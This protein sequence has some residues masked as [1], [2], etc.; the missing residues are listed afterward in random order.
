VAHRS[1]DLSELLDGVLDL[2]IEDAPVGDHNDRIEK[3]GFVLLKP[4][5]LMS[6]PSNGVGLAAAGRMLDQIALA[7]AVLADRSEQ[8][9]DHVELVI[10]GENLITFLLAGFLVFVFHHLGVVF[11]DVG[12]PLAG[13]DA[14]PEVTS[15]EPLRIGRIASTIVPALVEREKPGGFALE[16]GAEEDLL[17]IHREVHQTAPELEQ[18]LPRIAVASVLL[19]GVVDRLLGEAVLEPRRWQPAAR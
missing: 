7:H 12:Q 4:D 1:R 10:P 6:Q 3:V 8:L 14:L 5:Q 16:I 9:A 15:L 2:L 13:E 11:D 17:I 18:Q 19:D